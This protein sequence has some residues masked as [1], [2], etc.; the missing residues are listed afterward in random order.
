LGSESE[1]GFTALQ[2]FSIVEQAADTVDVFGDRDRPRELVRG[3]SR[4]CCYDVG[5]ATTS[6]DAN[7]GSYETASAA[8]VMSSDTWAGLVTNEA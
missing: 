4:V 5:G 8:L 6:R 2:I 1:A 7:I 3:N